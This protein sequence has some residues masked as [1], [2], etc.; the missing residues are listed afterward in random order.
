MAPTAIYAEDAE[1]VLDSIKPPPGVVIPPPGEMREVIEK[2]A[3]YVVRGG[4]GI[5]ARLRENHGSNPKFGFVL[6]SSDPFN[7]YYE[8]RKSEYKAGRGTAVAAGRVADP[9]KERKGPSKPPDF[10]FSARMPRIN[11]VDLEIV[12][13]TALF[14]AKHG[15]QLMTSLAQR[16]AGNP[17][18]HFLIPN[19]T[20]HNFFQHTVDQ[21]AIVLKESGA[22]GE[23]TRAQQ[24]RMDELQRNID[25][26]YNVLARAKQRVEYAKW[27]AAEKVKK[28]EEA[29]REKEEYLKIDWNDFV[30]VETIIFTESDDTTDLPPP[31]TLNDIQFASLEERNKVSI[32]ANRR[33]EEAFPFDNTTYNAY[34]LR[35]TFGFQNVPVQ[36]PQPQADPSQPIEAPPSHYYPHVLGAAPAAPPAAAPA[37]IVGAAGAGDEDRVGELDEETR[38]IR[39]REAAWQRK[40]QAQAEARGGAPMKIKENYMPRAAAR[41]ANRAD[42]HTVLCPNCKQPIAVGELEQ[43]M[44]STYT[45]PPL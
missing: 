4:A 36:P 7:P 25:D 8:W 30:I 26:K 28:Q 3:G 22:T 23:G 12:R 40:T 27:Q 10:R 39:E 41:V 19:H 33:I 18:F 16:E 15:R 17:Q 38:G 35:P 37:Y 31:T 32:S 5:E 44:K 34:P 43:H 29:Q 20:F 13:L 14:V 11:Q 24:S 45:P 2:T 42:S 1:A 9:A 6:T 21:Y